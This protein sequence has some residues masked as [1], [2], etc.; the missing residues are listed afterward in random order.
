MKLNYRTDKYFLDRSLIAVVVFVYCLFSS[1]T[2]DNLGV[3]ELVIA[4]FLVV[5]AL[6]SFYFGFFSSQRLI[7]ILFLIVMLQ[8]IYG[9][10]VAVI[11]FNDARLVLRDVIPMLYLSFG[12]L[13]SAYYFSSRGVVVLSHVLMLGGAIFML[14][15]FFEN[16]NLSISDIGENVFFTKGEYFLVEPLVL[17]S[18]LY[19][20]FNVFSRRTFLPIRIISGFVFI[21]FILA[22]SSQALRGYLFVLCI[23]VFWF[24]FSGRIFSLRSILVIIV[25][26]SFILI[27]EQANI[28]NA[29]I[30][31]NRLVG[32][33]NRL[34]EFLE[35]FSFN[36]NSFSAA[37]GGVGWGGGLN[38]STGGYL[39]FTHNIFSYLSMKLG[40]FIGLVGAICLTFV[41]LVYFLKRRKMVSIPSHVFACGITLL[42][43]FLVQPGFKMLG[44]GF[45]ISIFLSWLVVEHRKCSN[46]NVNI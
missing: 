34:S 20:F 43:F 10:L 35:V 1:A 16:S 42:Y 4:V 21:L 24:F 33:N 32:S 9:I 23:S 28:L 44:L 25:S 17:F 2:P 14:R 27:V 18:G 30:E 11:Y 36:F 29:L 26:V 46:E 6:R 41:I 5:L 19:S 38:L 8:L 13:F 39:R 7:L 12:V 31:K 45:L 40:L 3:A 15:H 22:F 37:I